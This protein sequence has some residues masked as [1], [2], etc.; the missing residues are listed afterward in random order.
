MTREGQEHIV[1]AR[2]AQLQPPGR[3]V[4]GV[5]SAHHLAEHD[6]AVGGWHLHDFTLEAEITIA[7]PGECLARGAGAFDIGHAYLDHRPTHAGLQLGRG[8]LGDHPAVVDDRDAVGEAVGLLEVLR[9]QQQRGPFA[10]EVFDDLPQLDAAAR[11]EPG[12]GFVEKQHRRVSDQ[13]RSEVE[14]ATHTTRIGAHRPVGGLG[15]VELSQ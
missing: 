8:A 10:H 12:R 1:E 2:L 3:Q 5:E 14:T 15:E 4:S 7:D 6:R 9:G 11:V 13:C